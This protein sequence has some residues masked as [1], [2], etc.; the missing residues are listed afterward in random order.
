MPL[1]AKIFRQAPGP[2]EENMAPCA[3]FGFKTS[4]VG[5]IPGSCYWFAAVREV[6]SSCHF[7]N[8]TLRL[9]FCFLQ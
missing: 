8:V 7:N 2:W 4:T 5:A 9:S 1:S 3:D 6:F